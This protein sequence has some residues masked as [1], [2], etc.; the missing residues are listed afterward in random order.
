MMLEW[1]KTLGI[2]FVIGAASVKPEDAASNISAWS[3]WFGIVAVLIVSAFF[4]W[5]IPLIK[6]I[7]QSWITKTATKKSGLSKKSIMISEAIRYVATVIGEEEDKDCFALTRHQLRQAAL[8]GEVKVRGNKSSEPN[9]TAWSAVQT[10]IPCGY[11]ET[12]EIGPLAIDKMHDLDT[13]T[14]PH[15][16]SN[17]KFGGLIFLY[18]KLRVDWCEIS[19]RWPGQNKQN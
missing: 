10:D 14:F 18:A 3:L 8:D 11:W 19:K 7:V 4:I 16:F 6:K 1:I 15:Q 13:H 2:P 17:G 5:R 9:G 12:A